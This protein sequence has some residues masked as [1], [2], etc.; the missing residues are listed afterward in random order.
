MDTLYETISVHSPMIEGVRVFILVGE[1]AVGFQHVKLKSIQTVR[2][3]MQRW[4]RRLLV[5]LVTTGR[6]TGW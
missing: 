3:Y 5:G 6:S 4:P 1:F 2:G